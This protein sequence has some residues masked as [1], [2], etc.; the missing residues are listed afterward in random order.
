MTHFKVDI[1]LPIKYNIVDGDLTREKVPD[2][3]FKRTYD[4]LLEMMSGIHTSNMAIM[5]SW[6]CPET[7]QVYHD[8]SIVFS[9]LVE[10]EDKKTVTNVPKIKKLREYKQ[11]LKTRFKQKEIFMVATRCCWIN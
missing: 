9:V 11:V 2:I 5:G 3:S 6:V 4:E 1:Q 10:S 8:E 7:K